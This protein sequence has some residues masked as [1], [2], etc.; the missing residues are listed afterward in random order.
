MQCGVG[1]SKLAA[2]I[3]AVATVTLAREAAAQ[4]SVTVDF[5]T[6]VT[7]DDAAPGYFTPFNLWAVWV[8]DNAGNFVQDHR[9]QTTR[10]RTCNT[11]SRGT[12]RPAD[13]RLTPTR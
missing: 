7:G 2:I 11:C 13:G 8:E 5:T 3:T 1:V 10:R 9:A 6:T 12:L 4:E